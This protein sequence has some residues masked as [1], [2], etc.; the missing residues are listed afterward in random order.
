MRTSKP[1]STIS[2][3]TEPFLRLTLD[4]LITNKVISFYAFIPHFPEDD[5]AGNKE[6]IHL[7]AEPCKLIQTEDIRDLFIEPC[8]TNS[9]AKPLGCITFRTSKFADWY[10]YSIH[11]EAYLASKGQKRR[12]HY[13]YEDVRTI[14]QD[15][16]LYRVRTIDLTST[17]PYQSMLEAQREGLTWDQ[18]F[19]RGTI[20]ITQL[21]LWRQAWFTLLAPSYTYRNGYDGHVINTETGEIDTPST[22]PTPE[23][24][25]QDAVKAQSYLAYLGY[26]A[27]PMIPLEND[28]DLP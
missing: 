15:E 17:S 28:E 22:P 6:H 27:I 2:Y 1:I 4:R 19:R 20:P 21:T 8:L 24:V 5:E 25:I 9:T 10:L 23:Q 11:D 13:K 7:Y 12:Y 18:Y 16:L 14:D 3:N 26:D